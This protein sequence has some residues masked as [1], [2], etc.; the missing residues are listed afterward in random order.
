M[1]HGSKDVTTAG[2]EV[3]LTATRTMCARLTIQAKPANTGYIY[4]GFGTV[5]SD[6]YGVRL[7]AGDSF[8]FGMGQTG[9]NVL[10]V[11][12]V[13]IDSSVNGEG[14]TYLGEQL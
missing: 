14:V 7:S 11:G 3:A 1:F 10:N 5:A 2:T 8:T 4:V 12:A 13:V 9:G 6:N